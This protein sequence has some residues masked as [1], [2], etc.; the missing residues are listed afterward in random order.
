LNIVI[1]DTDP[2]RIARIDKNLHLAF[3]RLGINGVVTCN[4]EPPSLARAGLFD[5]V[6]VLEIDGKHWRCR[7]KEPDVEACINLLRNRIGQQK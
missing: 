6:P 5:K 2:D 1:W 7:D 4:A 3:K